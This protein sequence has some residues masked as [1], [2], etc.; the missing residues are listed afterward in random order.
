MPREYSSHDMTDLA[1]KSASQ[2]ITGYRARRFSPVEALDAV[3][4]RIERCE[5]KLNAFQRVDPRRARR[6]AHASQERW[7]KKKPCG[8]VDGV[9]IAIK[10]VTET[11][12]WPTL[13]GSLAVDPAGPWNEDA[14]VV[15]RFRAHGAVLIGK[16]STPE[17]A[18][19]TTT[20]SALK[21][22]TRNPWNPEWTPAGSSGGSAAAVASG[23][24]HIATGTDS[25][26]SIRGP[27]SFCNI[28]G[29]KP[30]F[31]RV[32]VW[33]PSPMLMLE[34]CGP[35]AR[36]VRDA[37]LALQVMAGLDPR[38]GY[39]IQEP[40]PAFLPSLERGLRGLHIGY[41]P[42]LGVA[43][44]DPAVRHSVGEARTVFSDLGARVSRVRLDLSAYLAVANTFY[45][46]I[47]ARLARR[48]G[49]RRTRLRSPMLLEAARAGAKCN[50]A[51]FMEAEAQ[52]RDLRAQ[53]A[54]FH[55][56]YDLLITPSACVPPF[57]CGRDDPPGWSARHTTRWMA[58]TLAPFDLTGQP[59]ISV[60]C[61]FTPN[62]GPVGL[63]I[64]GPVGADALVLRAARAFERAH[65]VG[66]ER[67]PL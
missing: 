19:E 40:A 47:A 52:R 1:F 67:P 26:G 7:A 45:A 56:H 31:G 34:H 21:G 46:V 22:V 30:T 27:A 66:R 18:W 44:V 10:D 64:V 23:M 55:S 48:L 42:D 59:A 11:R 37:A 29:F 12:G 9:P 63:Q 8:L 61:G 49:R 41:S 36:T 16:T 6:A 32:P 33:P 3:L 15:E 4:A 35:L 54:R 39:A 43:R 13:N 2:L 62:G 57:A 5:P 28:V 53:M 60:P 20:Q 17:F 58:D 14:I 38:D 24:V 50:V 65:P 51:E 25:G